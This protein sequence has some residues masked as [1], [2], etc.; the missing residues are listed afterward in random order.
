MKSYRLTFP[1]EVTVEAVAA[2]LVVLAGESR[3]MRTTV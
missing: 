3:G 2:V 1:T